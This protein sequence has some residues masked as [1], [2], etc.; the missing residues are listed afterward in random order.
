MVLAKPTGAGVVAIIAVSDQQV[1]QQYWPCN[2]T[3]TLADAQLD[4]E[5]ANI[6]L[7][8]AQYHR[9]IFGHINNRCGLHATKTAVNN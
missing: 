3:G 7:A 8:T 5:V 4:I 9:A 1:A 6:A 2:A